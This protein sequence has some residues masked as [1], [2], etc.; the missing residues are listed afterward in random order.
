MPREKG[1][2]KPANIPIE[3]IERWTAFLAERKIPLS[4]EPTP[5][6]LMRAIFV[7]A[8]RIQ[9]S[10]M[11]VQPNPTL[12]EDPLSIG[13]IP[14]DSMTAKEWILMKKNPWTQQARRRALFQMAT[15][16]G[17]AGRIDD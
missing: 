3:D 11:M 17:Y 9:V 16:H 12:G 1:S 15:T 6:E 5:L 2:F 7:E 8:S 4:K 14:S 13:T 10:T